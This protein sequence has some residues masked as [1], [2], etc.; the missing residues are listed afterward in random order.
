MSAGGRY[1]AVTTVRTDFTLPALQMLGDAASRSPDPRELY[2]VDLA[3]PHA[4][5]G[6]PLLPAGATSTAT[7]RTGSRIYGRRKRGRLHLLRGQPL[8]RRRQSAHR[9]LRRDAAARPRR[10]AGRRGAGIERARPGRS[11]PKSGGPQIGARAKSR[12][13]A[14]SCSPSR[15]RRPAASRRSPRHAR[16]TPRKPRTLATDDG[17]GGRHAA[18]ARSSWRCDRSRA[19]GPSCASEGRSPAAPH[20]TYVASRGGR[21]ASAS[22]RGGLSRRRSTSKRRSKRGPEVKGWSPSGDDLETPLI[23]P[24]NADVEVL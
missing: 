22:L 23:T 1:L 2:M 21:R 7:C 12:P 9:R 5:T 18:A 4:R 17:A 14:S 16:A 24:C 19:I 15:F 10:R 3:E 11:K 13:A 20:V 6:H 8:P